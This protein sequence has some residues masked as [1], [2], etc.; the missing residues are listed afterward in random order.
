MTDDVRRHNPFDDLVDQIDFCL[1]I[2]P[3]KVIEVF[4]KTLEKVGIRVVLAAVSDEWPHPQVEL[5]VTLKDVTAKVVAQVVDPVL[6][7]AGV[8]PNMVLMLATAAGEAAVRF[9]QRQQQDLGRR[10]AT[11]GG[12]PA[13]DP[14]RMRR[15]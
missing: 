3:T 2:A 15:K 6:R 11:G 10:P 4:A 8:P 7:K 12:R 9:I 13:W 14:T 1:S 5:T